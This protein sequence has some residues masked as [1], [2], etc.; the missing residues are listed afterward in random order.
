MSRGPGKIELAALEAVQKMGEPRETSAADKR[1]TLETL[2]NAIVT[3]PD[4]L[5]RSEARAD[6]LQAELTE[7]RRRLIAIL[8]APDRRPWWRRWFGE[9]RIIRQRK[10]R[11]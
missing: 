10:L 4:Q 6:K 8:T 5:A 3:L 11:C 7:E 9:R 1:R 2:E